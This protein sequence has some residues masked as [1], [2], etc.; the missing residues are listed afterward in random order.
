MRVKGKNA[1]AF[2]ATAIKERCLTTTIYKMATSIGKKLL[3]L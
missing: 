2:I 3:K 1:E